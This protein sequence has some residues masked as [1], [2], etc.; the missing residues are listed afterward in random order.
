MSSRTESIKEYLV[1]TG[2]I[3]ADRITTRGY[4]PSGYSSG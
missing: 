2:G 3:S 4:G 1:V